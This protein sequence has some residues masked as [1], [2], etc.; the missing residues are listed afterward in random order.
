MRQ[1][2][3]NVARISGLEVV[4]VDAALG[5][6]MA[7]TDHRAS[8]S[9]S[10]ST[11]VPTSR[12]QRRWALT[13]LHFTSIPIWSILVLVVLNNLLKVSNLPLELADP[14]VVAFGGSL[15]DVHLVCQAV[16]LLGHVLVHLG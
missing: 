16:Q 12:A 15:K 2:R 9:A 5:R 4:D 8:A 10:L 11:T 14:L 13:A 7:T 3:L 6:G 1:Q